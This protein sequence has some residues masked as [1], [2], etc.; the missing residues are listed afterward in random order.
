MRQGTNGVG[1][2]CWSTKLARS[3]HEIEVKIVANLDPSATRRAPYRAD[4]DSRAASLFNG[5]VRLQGAD[6]LQVEATESSGLA[7]MDVQFL[8]E[9]LAL[10][11]SPAHRPI[12]LLFASRVPPISFG[13]SGDSGRPGI[14]TSCAPGFLSC[15]G[16][17]TEHTAAILLKARAHVR[18]PKGGAIPLLSGKVALTEVEAQKD[19]RIELRDGQFVL[20]LDRAGEFPV[21][22]SFNAAM[23]Q[24]DEWRS[25]DFAVAPGA[26]QRIRLTGLAVETRFRFAGAARPERAGN[27]FV[28]YLPPD[29]RIHLSWQETAPEAEGKLFFAAEMLSQ[30][31]VSPGLMTQAAL[32]DFKVM[33]GE[34]SQV[35]LLMHG[36]GEVTRVQGEQVLA[37]KVEPVVNSADRRLVAQL[38]QPQKDHFLFRSSSRHRSTHFR[39]VLRRCNCGRRTR[40]G[41]R[42]SIAW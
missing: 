16:Q 19:W 14:A 33:Q 37:W 11:A 26:L 21:R 1:I 23:T 34:L 22:L 12:P 15:S 28:S 38:N 31:T 10:R 41:S 20:R 18:S 40:R 5:Y 39:R 9:P 35:A 7:P 29:G 24:N 8:P 32:L 4:L 30:I 27:E 2:W 36:P 25:M 17:V 13:L 6:G 3:S 42:G